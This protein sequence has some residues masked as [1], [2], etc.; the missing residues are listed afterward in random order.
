MIKTS[1]I[2]P[3]YN[4]GENLRATL[5]SVVN[6][7]E[8]DIEIICVDDF[9]GDN[10]LDILK[11]YERKDSRIKVFQNIKKGTGAARNLGLKYAIG[12]TIIF[13]DS[14]DLFSP[15][16]ISELY[17]EYKRNDADVTFC[18]Y[19]SIKIKDYKSINLENLPGVR[20]FNDKI[21]TLNFPLSAKDIPDNIF[22]YFG[23]V[24][25]NKLYKM[26]FIKAN[27]LYFIN[28][29][30]SNDLY[31]VLLSLAFATK[32][33]Y[34]NKA[35]ILWCRHNKSTT[36]VRTGKN[37]YDVEIYEKIREELKSKGLYNLV[38]N[39]LQNAEWCSYL[40]ALSV[41]HNFSDFMIVSK[42]IKKHL[43]VFFPEYIY[44][45]IYYRPL[46]LLKLTHPIFLYIYLR[47][48]KIITKF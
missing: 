43:R 48:K 22:L 8:R 16:L 28:T 2:I 9:S 25:W 14:D 10:S 11:E 27:N 39:S 35:L 38:K 21:L 24:C 44:S 19:N 40:Y 42:K 6:Q 29:P 13:L 37:F 23:F 32:I 15:E 12:E 33:C 34:V 30:N 47:H 31:F 20:I 45:N 7:S 4:R 18:D 5:D 26:E 1:I 3:V 46:L 17:N 36:N 41:L